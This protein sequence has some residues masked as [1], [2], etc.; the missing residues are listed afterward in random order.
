MDQLA[1]LTWVKE[2]IEFFGG[3]PGSVTIFGESAGAMSVSGLVSF[4]PVRE[5]AATRV[6]RVALRERSL[7]WSLS[8]P[9]AACRGRA[10]KCRRRWCRP[11]ASSSDT[12]RIGPGFRGDCMST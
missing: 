11:S 12:C 8:A 9:T 5:V 3:D 7:V 10:E 2:N 1:T 4:P 6:R